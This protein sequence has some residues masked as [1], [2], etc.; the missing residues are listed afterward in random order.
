MSK[1]KM[2]MVK[3]LPVGTVIRFFYNSYD[4]FTIAPRSGHNYGNYLEKVCLKDQR[5][6]D[7][8]C[9][10]H[11]MILDSEDD[12]KR[13]DGAKGWIVSRLGEIITDQREEEVV[14]WLEPLVEWDR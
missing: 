4:E 10:D 8:W 12:G 1:P 2:T 6:T 3:D 13:S 11:E 14:Q 7:R 9:P 5:G